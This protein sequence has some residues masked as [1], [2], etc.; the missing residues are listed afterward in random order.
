M[1]MVLRQQQQLTGQHPCDLTSYAW[2]VE[3]PFTLVKMNI[4]HVFSV[5]L[6]IKFLI[7]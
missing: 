4:L 2:V 5:V 3:L 7:L 1:L 6:C